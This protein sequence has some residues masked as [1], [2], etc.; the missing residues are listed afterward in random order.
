MP[1]AYKRKYNHPLCYDKSQ[2]DI[3]LHCSKLSTL[4]KAWHSG[5][6]LYS[7]EAGGSLGLRPVSSTQRVPGQPEL[8][9][10]ETLPQKNI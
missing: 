10:K 4:C 2:K 7:L 8:Y 9:N 1:N 3:V 6:H 5:T